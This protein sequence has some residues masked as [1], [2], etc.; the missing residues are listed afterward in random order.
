LEPIGTVSYVSTPSEEAS[1]IFLWRVDSWLTLRVKS[2]PSELAYEA[3]EPLFARDVSGSDLT[4]CL[5]WETSQRQTIRDARFVSVHDMSPWS[6]T[7]VELLADQSGSDGSSGT[8]APLPPRG[9]RGPNVKSNRP[10]RP[11]EDESLSPS[12]DD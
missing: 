10:P 12:S 8:I 3:T 9:P 2:E 4:V 7:L 11:A 1:N 6:I 5:S